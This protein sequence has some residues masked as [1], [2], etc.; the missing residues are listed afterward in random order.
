MS[1]DPV[2]LPNSNKQYGAKK[3]HLINVAIPN[4]GNIRQ[5][6]HEKLEKYQELREELERSRQVKSTVVP[7]QLGQLE[8]HWTY[9]PRKVHS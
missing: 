5:Q 1:K 8:K 7:D 3:S 6:D 9:Q 4:D 2:V